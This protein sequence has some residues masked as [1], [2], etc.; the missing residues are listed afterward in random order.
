MIWYR[1]LFSGQ[2][3][4]ILWVLLDSFEIE[5]SLF[6]TLTNKGKHKGLP[7]QENFVLN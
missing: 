3:N 6:A 5:R 4:D 7:L 1:P 2:E